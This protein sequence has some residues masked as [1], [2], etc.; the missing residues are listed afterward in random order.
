MPILPRLL[1]NPR[2]LIGAHQPGQW[3]PDVG[4]EVA[5]AGRSNVGKS[6]ALNTLVLRRDLARTSKTPGRTQQIV[7]Y[8]LDEDRRL[9]DLPGYGYAKVPESLRRHWARV[10]ERFLRTRSS[11]RGLVLLMDIRHPLT[12]LDRRLLDWCES[13]GLAVHILLTKMDKFSRSKAHQNLLQVR[14]ELSTRGNA[15]SAQLFSSANRHGSEEAR[16]RIV[17]WLED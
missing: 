16:D 14:A 9:V 11:L 13:T 6:S 4:A 1:H 3:P 10:I 17:R 2:F 8:L 12:P 5:F 15:I 7:F